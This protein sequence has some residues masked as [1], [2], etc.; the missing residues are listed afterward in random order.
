MGQCQNGLT[1]LD[2]SKF[3]K[4]LDSQSSKVPSKSQAVFIGEY[5][6]CSSRAS[7]ISWYSE[8]LLMSPCLRSVSN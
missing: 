1:F 4:V 8:S 6:E 2:N 7:A 5:G 3:G